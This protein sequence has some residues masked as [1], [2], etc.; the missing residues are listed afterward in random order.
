MIDIAEVEWSCAAYVAR[1]C[2]KKLHQKNVYE[3]AEEGKLPEFVRMSRNIGRFYFE[4]NKYK[5]YEYDEIV[6]K[7]IKGNTGAFKPPKA[8]DRLFKNLHPDKW[9]EWMK[10]DENL[11]HTNLTLDDLWEICQY[12]IYVWM[13]CYLEGGM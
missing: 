8:W 7:T 10:E 12:I 1:Y 9:E 2:M 5:I 11:P 6:M 13:P 4:K 3:Y